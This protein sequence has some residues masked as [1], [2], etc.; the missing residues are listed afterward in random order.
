MSNVS[1][2]IGA[3]KQFSAQPQDVYQQRLTDK[4]TVAPNDDTAA[5]LA[6]SLGVFGQTIDTELADREKRKEKLGVYAVDKLLAGKDNKSLETMKSI[7]MLQ[8]FTEFDI[9]DNPYAKVHLEKIRGKTASAK[10]KL[11]YQE[12]KAEQGYDDIKSDTDEA[13]RYDKFLSERF[14]KSAELALDQDAFKAGFYDNHLVDQIDQIEGYRKYRTNEYKQLQKSNATAEFSDVV[15][16][17]LSVPKEETKDGI[18]KVFNSDALSGTSLTDRTE[19]G[20]L[21]LNSLAARTGDPEQVQYLADNITVGTDADGK[22]V[23][24][25][26]AVGDLTSVTEIAAV[27]RTQM[28]EERTAADHG[29]LMEMGARKDVDD[30][31]DELKKNDP[32]FFITMTPFRDNAYANIAKRDTAKRVAFQKGLEDTHLKDKKQTILDANYNAHYAGNPRDGLNNLTAV[33]LAGLPKIPYTGFHADG[34]GIKKEYTLTAED[35][36]EWGT[37]QMEFIRKKNAGDEKATGYNLMQLLSYPPMKEFAGSFKNTMSSALANL[38]PDRLAYDGEGKA[39]VTGAVKDAMVLYDSNPEVFHQLFGGETTKDVELIKALTQASGGDMKLGVQAY[40]TSRDARKDP[41]VKRQVEN[42]VQSKID[43]STLSGFLEHDGSTITLKKGIAGNAEME[44]RVKELTEALVYG[45]MDVDSAWDNAVKSANKTH[46]V[47][48]ETAIPKAVW[49]GVYSPDKQQVGQKVLD[50]YVGITGQ[51]GG[52]D[53]S[54][55]SVKWNYYRNVLE[56]RAN[57]ASLSLSADQLAWAGNY[58][59]QQEQKDAQGVTT[60]NYNQ[61]LDDSQKEE[62]KWVLP[63]GAYWGI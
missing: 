56:L 48:K 15:F 60:Y 59:L 63:E 13:A 36:A 53:P 52:V 20:K 34:T 46:Y 22:P 38:S 25:K 33:S 28:Y 17:S 55:V 8:S 10:A 39:M 3:Q 42:Q 6:R 45:G 31:F 50:Y 16:K 41:T 51:K 24:L 47:Y 37:N 35:L 5:Q 21:L 4:I 44:S 14:G 27:R 19:Q 49:N 26:D 9:M 62:S 30:Y 2:A 32:N 54:H 12:Y 1:N 40:A 23:T 11:E 58:V 57:N 43:R 61:Y 18:Q 7:D 29:I